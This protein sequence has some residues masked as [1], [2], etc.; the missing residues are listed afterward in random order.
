[1][2]DFVSFRLIPKG[3]KGS[4]GT[5]RGRGKGEKKTTQELIRVRTEN[6]TSSETHRL[7]T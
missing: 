7:L 5:T 2:Y 6:F 1:M 4:L 3:V